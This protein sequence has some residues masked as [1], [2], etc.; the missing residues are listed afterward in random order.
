LPKL[1]HGDELLG[2][3]AL[4]ILGVLSVIHSGRATIQGSS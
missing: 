2:K 4:L 1:G 3:N